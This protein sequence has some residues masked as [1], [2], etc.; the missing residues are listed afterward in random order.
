MKKSVSASV[1]ES[2]CVKMG[3]C[4]EL[5]RSEVSIDPFDIP[6]LFN[7]FSKSQYLILLILLTTLTR[8]FYISGCR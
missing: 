5:G 2:L 3:K 4:S 1:S 6:G 8:Y 7:R